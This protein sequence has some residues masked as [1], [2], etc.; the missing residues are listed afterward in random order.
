[1]TVFGYDSNCQDCETDGEDMKLVKLR[2]DEEAD[3]GL[4]GA[5]P[6]VTAKV[7]FSP[8]QRVGRCLSRAGFTCGIVAGGLFC[9]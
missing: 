3:D 2:R 7:T 9:L 6:Q 1:M 8:R 4:R 5:S